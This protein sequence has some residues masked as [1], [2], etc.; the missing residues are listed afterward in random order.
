LTIC[1]SLSR[2]YAKIELNRTS[3]LFCSLFNNEWSHKLHC[4]SW[5]WT[6]I[7]TATLLKTIIFSKTFLLVLQKMILLGTILLCICA[8]FS[9]CIYGQLVCF[10]FLTNINSAVMNTRVQMSPQH[11]FILFHIHI[12][13]YI[14]IIYIL[15]ILTGLTGHMFSIVDVHIYISTIVCKGFLFSFSKLTLVFCT[16]FFFLFKG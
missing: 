14:Y 4:T 12:W 15:Y 7:H 8:I 11:N 9:F 2:K 1:T 3:I 6:L 16:V 5:K 13:N 10:H